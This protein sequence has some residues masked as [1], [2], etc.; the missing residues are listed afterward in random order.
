MVQGTQAQ[1]FDVWDDHTVKEPRYYTPYQ[2]Y[3]SFLPVFSGAYVFDEQM[4]PN[5]DVKEFFKN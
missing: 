2:S 3:T 1:N 5:E 4:V